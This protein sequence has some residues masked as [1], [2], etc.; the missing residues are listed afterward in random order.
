MNKVDEERILEFGRN[1]NKV[2]IT[3]HISL[4]ILFWIFGVKVMVVVNIGSVLTYAILLCFGGKHPIINY[5]IVYIE[6]VVHMAMATICLGWNTGFTMYCFSLIPVAYYSDFFLKK[7]YEGY[8][9]SRI[10]SLFV[11]VSYFLLRIYTYIVPQIY[12]VN[13]KSALVM[14]ILNSV[15]TFIFIAGCFRVFEARTIESEEQY[16]KLANIDE[17]TGMKNRRNM[18][19]FMD[20]TINSENGNRIGVSLAIIDIDNFK[21]VNDTYGHNAGDYI[22]KQVAAAFKNNETDKIRAC[23]WGGEEFVIF[24]SGEEGYMQTVQI[25]QNVLEI[26]YKQTY[27]YERKDIRVS[28][29]AGVTKYKEHETLDQ[30]I[31]RADQYL[32]EGKEN[33]KNQLVLDDNIMIQIK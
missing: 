8:N 2:L 26:I 9:Y 12:T 16:N 7:V 31:S 29:T 22:L 19:K 30:L 32:Y 21:N 33:G 24:A 18:Q 25:V 11:I 5:F 20:K 28:L 27:V 4:L 3:I 10:L 13:Q 17:L 6:I 14:S 23:R 15:V 1:V